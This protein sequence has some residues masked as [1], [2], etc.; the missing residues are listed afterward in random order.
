VHYP[1]AVPAGPIRLT[2]GE[3]ANRPGH[4]TSDSDDY[5][6]IRITH[7]NNVDR[8]DDNGH[9]WI[10]VRGHDPLTCH[11]E[12]TGPHMPC[13]RVMARTDALAR[14]AG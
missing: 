11:L 12:S 14:H 9:T 7:I 4:D 6:D 3:W 1:R 8:W 13:I 5:V 10:W 2:A